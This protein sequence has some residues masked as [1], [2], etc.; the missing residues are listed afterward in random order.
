MAVPQGV[1]DKLTSHAHNFGWTVQ[2]WRHGAKLARVE[3]DRA[4]ERAD[5]ARAALDQLISVID[6]VAAAGRR[7]AAIGP[8]LTAEINKL[9][10]AL[11]DA[12]PL[13]DDCRPDAV[14]MRSLKD[15]VRATNRAAGWPCS[16]PPRLAPVYSSNDATNTEIDTTSIRP[17]RWIETEAATWERVCG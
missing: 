14:R 3:R 16:S 7:A 2:E 15:S 17:L 9:T 8:A 10:G 13:P 4:Q 12:P 5:A 6:T 11:K 1:W